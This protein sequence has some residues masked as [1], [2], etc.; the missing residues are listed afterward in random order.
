MEKVTGKERQLSKRGEL[1]SLL[2]T[3]KEERSVRN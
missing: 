1:R 2:V 3:L